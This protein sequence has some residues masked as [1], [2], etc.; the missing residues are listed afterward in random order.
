MP[1][2]KASI[3]VY[4]AICYLKIQGGWELCKTESIESLLD[5][6]VAMVA[7]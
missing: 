6:P 7:L 2:Q 1:G 4:I 3:F 5:A